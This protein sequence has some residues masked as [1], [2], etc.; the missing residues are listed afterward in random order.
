M[1]QLVLPKACRDPVLQMAY[2]I[3]KAGHFGR[4][5]L[6]SEF[7]RGSSGLVLARMLQV[8][9]KQVAPAP[10]I[11]LP[12]TAERSPELLLILLGLFQG[13]GPGTALYL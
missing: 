2:A 10:L 1:E 9:S 6:L 13:A 8:S 4:K 5:K 11:H 3:P 12:V 7:Y